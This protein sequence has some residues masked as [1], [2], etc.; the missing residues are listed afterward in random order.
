[1]GVIAVIKAAILVHTLAKK[2]SVDT[3][4]DHSCR[5]PSSEA[6]R[7]DVFHDHRGHKYNTIV[8]APY[9]RHYDGASSDHAM[10]AYMDIE[11][12]VI[13]EIVSENN[14]FKGYRRVLADVNAARVR[15][16]E[17]RAERDRYPFCNIHALKTREPLSANFTQHGCQ[18]SPY[19]RRERIIFYPRAGFELSESIWDSQIGL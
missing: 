16:V 7:R 14:D 1:M 12:A 2:G 18:S 17:P 13:Y 9:T 4:L 5:T 8:T 19:S 11:K 6:I 10:F 3:T 15:L